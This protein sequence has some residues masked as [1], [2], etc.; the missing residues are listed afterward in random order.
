MY[1]SANSVNFASVST[2][3]LLT[4][5]ENSQIYL[6]NTGN[7][8]I[9][10]SSPA[11][12]LDVEQ[13][14]TGTSGTAYMDYNV[15]TVNPASTSSGNYAANR[16]YSSI[17]TNSNITG[18]V[19]GSVSITYNNGT[20]TL[21][22]GFGTQNQIVNNSTGAITAA[23]GIWNQAQNSAAGGT[24]TTAQGAFNDAINLGTSGV[25]VTTAEGAEN[26]AENNSTGTVTT[27][28][29]SY[30]TAQNKST[31][32]ITTAAGAKNNIS[33]ATG[34]TIGTA[35]G[36]YNGA[37][38]AGTVTNWYNLYLAAPPAPAPSATTTQS[39][40]PIPARAISRAPSSSAR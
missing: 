8:G 26:I 7:V 5:G 30:N 19:N 34:G 17:T 27:A 31:G 35:Y 33:N 25:G 36:L 24:I 38:N 4:L 9:G 20:G 12:L 2:A 15:L 29:G 3:G 11:H 1:D 16:A 21:T 13:T 23:E 18:Q 14:A 39:T 28:Y 32:T 22:Q 10:I 6:P 37:A 40:A